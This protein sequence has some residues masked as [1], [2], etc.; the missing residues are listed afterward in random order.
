MPAAA[1]TAHRS[2]YTGKRAYSSAPRQIGRLSIVGASRSI[3]ITKA[4]KTIWAR[5]QAALGAVTPQ[6]IAGAALEELQQLGLT[7]RKVGYMQDFARKVYRLFQR[8]FHALSIRPE[9][10]RRQGVNTGNSVSEK[11]A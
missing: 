5:M 10:R 2:R 11:K 7:F 9:R 4:Q 8:V 6:T 3:S 1:K